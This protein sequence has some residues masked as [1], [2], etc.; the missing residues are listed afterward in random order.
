M[1]LNEYGYRRVT[2]GVDVLLTRDGLQRFKDS[3]LGRGY[4][5]KVPG[6][7]RL[8]DTALNV[9]IDVLLTGSYPGDGLP[10]PISFPDPAEVAIRTGGSR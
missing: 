4:V 7:R 2:V 1:A 3:W 8:C 6:G 10:K 5:E 9:A